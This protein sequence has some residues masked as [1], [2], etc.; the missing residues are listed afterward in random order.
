MTQQKRLNTISLIST[1]AAPGS[2][3]AAN[4]TTLQARAAG[5]YSLLTGLLIQMSYTAT[6]SGTVTVTVP[7]ILQMLAGLTIKHTGITRLNSWNGYSLARRALQAGE[8]ISPD[9]TTATV[10]AAVPTTTATV[11]TVIPVPLAFGSTRNKRDLRCGIPLSEMANGELRVVLKGA[12]ITGDGTNGFAAGNITITV[13]GIVE[14]LDNPVDVMLVEEHEIIEAGSKEELPGTGTMRRLVYCLV[15][16]D[17]DATALTMPTGYTI[18]IDG[19]KYATSQAGAT[20]VLLVNL[21]RQDGVNDILTAVCPVFSLDRCGFDISNAP[22]ATGKVVLEGVGSQ[23]SGSHKT[24]SAYAY[25]PDNSTLTQILQRWQV[26]DAVI[27]GYFAELN[28]SSGDQSVA[29]VGKV[30]LVH[31][32]ATDLDGDAPV[33]LRG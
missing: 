29:R 11:T 7:E 33:T 21:A 22:L 6:K 2:T 28:A 25:R 17:A 10:N 1:V 31:I 12:Q 8:F 18:D 23:H 13:D 14:E 9:N 19:T 26:P 24:L 5:K 20:Q 27:N 16:D 15:A 4:L 30:P 32:D 3:I